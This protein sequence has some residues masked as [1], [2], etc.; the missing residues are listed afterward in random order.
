M[1]TFLNNFSKDIVCVSKSV[2]DFWIQMG[3]KKNKLKIVNNG[4]IF[5]NIKP[6]IFNKEKIIFT[7]ISR[8]IPYKGHMLL[9]EIFDELF[10]KNDKIQLQIVGDTLPQYQKYLDDLKLNIKK[11]GIEDRI[12]FLGFRNDISYILSNSNFLIHTPISPDP[13]PTV[14]FEAI[15]S[16]TP[17]ITNNLGGAYEILNNGING[18][19]INN[20]M[21]ESSVELIMSYMENQELKN[22]NVKDAFDYVCN[23]FSLEKFKSKILDIIE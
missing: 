12:M 16:K 6:K 1:V 7:S 14:I 2:K 13:F 10:K 22:K 19:I 11:K 21:I 9:I 4:F 5:K 17:V 18:L 15:K 20:D 3:I 8:I 23:K